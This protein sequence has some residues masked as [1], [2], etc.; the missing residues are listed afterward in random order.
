MLDTHIHFDAVGASTYG[1]LR[2][3][4]EA[5]ASLAVDIRDLYFPDD[6]VGDDVLGRWAERRGVRVER[7]NVGDLLWSLSIDF[8]CPYFDEDMWNDIRT[9]LDKEDPDL[10]PSFRVCLLGDLVEAAVDDLLPR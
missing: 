1:A 10:L 4:A 7:V 2:G 3:L 8:F 5:D 6:F 9:A